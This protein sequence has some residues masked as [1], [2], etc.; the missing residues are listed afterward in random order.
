M[1][2]LMALA[3]KPGI[4]SGRGECSVRK[5]KN[6]SQKMPELISFE[7]FVGILFH[8]VSMTFFTFFYHE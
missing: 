5:P 4:F 2:K 6:M 1:E 8:T 7:G 3:L